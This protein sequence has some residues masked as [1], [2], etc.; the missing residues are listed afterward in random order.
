MLFLKQIQV[1]IY[2]IWQPIEILRFQQ[3]T[4]SNVLAY[5]IKKAGSKPAFFIGHVLFRL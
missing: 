3:L 1:A 2:W 4:N 5:S